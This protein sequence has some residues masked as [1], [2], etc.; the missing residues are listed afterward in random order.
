MNRP[1][2]EGEILLVNALLANVSDGWRTLTPLEELNV[3][4]MDDGGMG[5][6][7]F[8]P[9]NTD[10]HFGRQLVEGWYLDADEIPISVSINIDQFGELY[11][12]DSWKVDFAK[13]ISLPDRISDVQHGWMEPGIGP[14]PA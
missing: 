8:E 14:R 5:S 9:A 12:L 7:R 11:E 1:L 2:N 3:R 6:L 10:R 13:R 4:D